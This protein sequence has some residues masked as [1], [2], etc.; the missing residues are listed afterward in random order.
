MAIR[1]AA[2]SKDQADLLLGK[3]ESHFFDG[4][5]DKGNQACK[6]LESYFRLMNAD[7]GPDKPA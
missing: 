2:V 7:G 5:Q 3:Q 1:A 6:A 4:C